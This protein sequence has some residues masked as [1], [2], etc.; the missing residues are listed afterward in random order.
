MIARGMV[1]RWGM[2]PELGPIFLDSDNPYGIEQRADSVEAE[3]RRI[4]ESAEQETVELLREHRGQ[5]DSL[6]ARLLEKETVDQDEVYE[7]VG[8][9][10]AGEDES[11]PAPT[12][13]A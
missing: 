4:V 7:V 5:L 9:E 2:S 8:I 6:V 10:P 12:A 13:A 3:V 1:T 11:A